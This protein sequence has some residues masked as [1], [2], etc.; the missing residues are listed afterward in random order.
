MD[1]PSTVILRVKVSEYRK[2]V[3]DVSD[4]KRYYS[5]L[6]PMAFVFCFPKNASEWG[7]VAPANGGDALK[8]QSGF[9]A[10]IDQIIGYATRIED[11]PKSA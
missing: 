10:H 7:L 6:S 4:G 1:Q 9:E 11:S 8:W 2:I 3:V 5:D